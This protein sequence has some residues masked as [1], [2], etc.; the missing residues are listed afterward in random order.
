MTEPD[1]IVLVTYG[2]DSYD[3]EMTHSRD[4]LYSLSGDAIIT[5]PNP[6]T[7]RFELSTGTWKTFRVFDLPPLPVPEGFTGVSGVTVSESADRTQVTVGLGACG[8]TEATYLACKVATSAQSAVPGFPVSSDP[9]IVIPA[10]D[11]Y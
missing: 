4:N 6:G 2:A 1:C 11:P 9:K 5:P 7:I 10:D 3:M 8:G